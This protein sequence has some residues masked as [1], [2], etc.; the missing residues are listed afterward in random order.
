[1]KQLIIENDENCVGCGLCMY[2]CARRLGEVGIRSSGILATSKS[3]FERGA[4]IIVCRAC[5]DP[6]CAAV[7][8]TEALTPKDGGGVSYHEGRCTGCENC[9]YACAIDAI[10]KKE[11]GKIAICIHCGYCEDYCPHGVLSYKEVERS[12]LEARG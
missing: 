1:M 9:I 3:G 2:A 10:S 6:P 7:C 4:K 12:K 5:G 11:D 8:P